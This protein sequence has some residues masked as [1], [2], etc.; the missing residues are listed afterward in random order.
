MT[1]GPSRALAGIA[2][3]GLYILLW[4]VTAIALAAL[5]MDWWL[6]VMV[7]AVAFLSWPSPGS[8]DER[9]PFLSRKGSRLRSGLL[10]TVFG[11]GVFLLARAV[12]SI[13]SR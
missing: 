3:W 7:F 6:A 4:L 5:R 12:L 8:R 11:L 13:L 10:F 1:K 9:A 2:P